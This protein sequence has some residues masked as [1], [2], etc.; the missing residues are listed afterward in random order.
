MRHARTL[1]ALAAAL[2]MT[3]ASSSAGA[4]HRS[5]LVGRAPSW[6]TPAYAQRVFEAGAAGMALPRDA[7]VPLS[8]LAFIGIRPG[9]LLII[10][11]EA[12]LTRAN[13][14]ALCTSNFVF[15][16]SAARVGHGRKARLAA[17]AAPSYFIGTAGHCGKQG[18]HVF[19][20]F[21]PLGAAHLGQITQSTGEPGGDKLAPDFALVSIDPELNQ[22]VSPSMAYWG[23]PT[24]V[25]TGGGIQPI[26][27]T[28]WGL[29]IGTGGTPRAGI[30]YQWGDEYRFEGAVTP[31][32]SGSGAIVAGGLAAGNITHIAVDTRE[33]VPV[34]NG[35]T[36]ILRI[37]RLVGNLQLAT[38]SLAIPWPA[39]G[40]PPV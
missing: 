27:H 18:D 32:D 36:S 31:G 12:E 35:G 24:G 33:D 8:S 21:A 22:W 28:G 26:L 23:G 34:W 14:F 11:D 6:F 15:T 38:C 3:V 20:L 13:G 7:H 10:S 30:A 4:P 1:A 40:C 19:M 2:S 37:L 9:Q 5:P 16:G 25:F 17:A 39:P 29:G